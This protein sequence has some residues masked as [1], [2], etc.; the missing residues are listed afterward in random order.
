MSTPPKD[1]EDDLSDP[2]RDMWPEPEDGP[3]P[4]YEL[5]EPNPNEDQDALDG[6]VPFDDE[7]KEPEASEFDPMA[8]AT[9]SWF[10]VLAWIGW[11]TSED[12]RKCC[13]DY[14][15]ACFRYHELTSFEPAGERGARKRLGGLA[16]TK[17]VWRSDGPMTGHIFASRAASRAKSLRVPFEK[18]EPTLT[19]A[20]IEG[21][22]TASAADAVSHR[23]VEVPS[24]HWAHIEI[25][26]SADLCFSH[27]T[28]KV[29]Y[30]DVKFLRSDVMGVWSPSSEDESSGA[31][32]R[33]GAPGRPTSMHLVEAEF[34]RR[35][36]EGVVEPTT[37]AE[38]IVLKSWLEKVHPGETPLTKKTIQNRLPSIRRKLQ[39]ARN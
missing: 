39:S 25:T 32:S 31:K 27:T 36:S 34:R 17:R 28:G 29:A 22:I 18:I 8:M 10:M 26:D 38:A 9:W 12:V 2:G 30:S 35:M 7:A 37:E 21:R 16:R 3:Q 23:P 19:N 33:S 24:L 14:R 13:D 5:D 6:H 11:R 4:D 1:D 20:L 15:T